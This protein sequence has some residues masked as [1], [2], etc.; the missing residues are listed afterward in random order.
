MDIVRDIVT[1]IVRAIAV[2]I[3][4]DIVRDM[5]GDIVRVL[6]PVFVFKF[7]KPPCTVPWPGFFFKNS[8]QGIGQGWG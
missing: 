5:V 3:L 4:R 7:R 8:G 2:D 1:D 6:W